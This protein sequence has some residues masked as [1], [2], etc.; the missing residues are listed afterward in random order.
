V[1]RARIRPK[2]IERLIE[3]LREKSQGKAVHAMVMHTNVLSEAEELRQRIASEVACVEVYV[4]DFTPVMGLHTGPGLL[5][6]AFYCDG[7]MPGSTD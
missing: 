6:I 7:M 3:L 2:A 1:D 5:G 4:T